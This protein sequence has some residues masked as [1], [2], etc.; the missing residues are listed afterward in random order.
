MTDYPSIGGKDRIF[1]AFDFPERVVHGGTGKCQREKTHKNVLDFSASTNPY[2]PSF[3]WNPI[4]QLCRII[5]MI[6]MT[7]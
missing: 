7:N 2:P 4:H 5:R 6:L 3:P 1:M